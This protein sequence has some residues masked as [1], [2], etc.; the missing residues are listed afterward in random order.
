[1]V[2]IASKS[3][4]KRMSRSSILVVTLFVA[5]LA[6]CGA[7][8]PDGPGAAFASASDEDSAAGIQVIEGA[9]DDS[10]GA[11]S[12]GHDEPADDAHDDGTAEQEPDAHESGDAHDAEEHA[13]GGDPSHD[14]GGNE[15][16]DESGEEMHDEGGDAHDAEGEAPHD[17]T[18]DAHDESGHDETSDAVEVAGDAGFVVEVEMLEF[19]FALDTTKV[20]MGEPV[21]FR[22]HNTGVIE[23]EAMFGSAHEQ[24]EFAT[25]GG[26]GDGHGGDS[27]H[28]DIAA[29]TLDAGATGEMVL[30]FDTPDEI[31]IG[32]HIAGHWDAGMQTTFEVA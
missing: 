7:D 30:S 22:F 2:D 12:A 6:G 15:M 26:H 32:C 27:H 16:L 11:E 5:A 21:T 10:H 4:S 8:G 25:S 17:E 3:R 28:G 13:D 18:D 14:E 29:I 9:A 31:W 23:H 20:P 1:M 19:G 24:E